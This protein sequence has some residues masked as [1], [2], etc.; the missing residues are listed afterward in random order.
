MDNKIIVHKLPDFEF[1]ELYPVCDFH[2]G[3]PKTDER[4][5]EGFVKFIAAEPNRYWLYAGDNLNNAIKSSVSNVY[6]EKRSPHQQKEHFIELMKPIADKC[7]CFVPGNHEARSSKETDCQ[8]VWD[9]A[10][11]LVGDDRARE[12]YRENE[13]FIKISFGRYIEKNRSHIQPVTYILW[14]VHGDGGGMYIGNTINKMQLRSMAIE[15][16]DIAICGHVHKGKVGHSF[17]VRVIDPHNNIVRM[18]SVSNAICCAWQDFS[19][20]AARKLMLPGAKGA[21]P[22]VF[23]GRRKEIEVRVGSAV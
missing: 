2:D 14:V 16:L 13:A 12:L 20:Y 9:I 6:N 10:C 8:L 17:P 23:S 21:L 11:R 22:I 15:G 7:F 4:M 3:D 1:I 19:G 5:F 18:R